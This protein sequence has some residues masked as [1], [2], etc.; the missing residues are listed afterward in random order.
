M[1]C[2][3]C[4]T[5]IKE[6][7]DFCTNCGKKFKGN[8]ATTNNIQIKPIYIIISVI[9]VAIVVTLAIVF[10]MKKPSESSNSND[11]IESTEEQVQEGT[12]SKIEI[13]VE[14]N[15]TTYG[16]L[17]YFKFEN[18]TL[19]SMCTGIANSEGIMVSGNYKIEG[20][21][22]KLTV[23]YDSTLIDPTE[24]TSQLAEPYDIEM[25]LLN[26]GTIKY[27]NLAGYTEIFDKN[28]KAQEVDTSIVQANLL[29]QIYAKYPE[30]KGTEG[31]IC[32]D[33]ELYWLL[34]KN[35]A[36]DYFYSFEEFDVKWQNYSAST[37][38]NSQQQEQEPINNNTNTS[39]STQN[40]S[41]NNSNSNNSSNNTSSSTQNNTS[42]N[43]VNNNKP[44]D[45]SI[46]LNDISSSNYPNFQDAKKAIE[47][48]GLKV[49]ELVEKIEKGFLFM[50]E[51]TDL[52]KY[53]DYKESYEK[54][55]T[56][57]ILHTIYVATD[58]EIRFSVGFGAITEDKNIIPLLSSNVSDEG[59]K[60]YFDDEF[61]FEYTNKKATSSDKAYKYSI[62]PNKKIHVK[63]VADYYIEGSRYEEDKIVNKQYVITE[64]DLDTSTHKLQYYDL[65]KRESWYFGM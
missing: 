62:P 18:E 24:P 35:G 43:D 30:L 6:G 57:D 46:S 36:K 53:K 61:A 28:A 40:S 64:Y 16:T 17:G 26:D 27:V 29:E 38:N 63:L 44:V 56:V 49:N 45:T 14:Y 41:N 13:G 52:W 8:V 31:I 60:V 32:T 7:N 54:G 11:V 25:T 1:L 47:A 21:K 22:I 55:D 39:S 5:E 23:T 33:G 9:V 65:Y 48:K 34:D 4:G 3:K 50:P 12:E 10:S 15:S 58:S 37:S 51:E 2:K 59:V 19:F 20:D 42:S